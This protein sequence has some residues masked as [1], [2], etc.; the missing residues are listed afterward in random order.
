MSR[1]RSCGRSKHSNSPGD[2]GLLVIFRVRGIRLQGKSID[3]VMVD[4]LGS[5]N[6]PVRELI[7]AVGAYGVG[8]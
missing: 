3:N 7:Q 2:N 1:R 5:G 6:C 8:R 4:S